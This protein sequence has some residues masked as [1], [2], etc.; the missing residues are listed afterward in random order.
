MSH[1]EWWVVVLQLGRSSFVA[2]LLSFEAVL[3]K[4]KCATESV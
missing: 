1:S 3:V 2:G 4:C